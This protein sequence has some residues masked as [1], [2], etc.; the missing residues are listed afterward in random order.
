MHKVGGVLARGQL[1]YRVK[2]FAEAQAFAIKRHAS[3]A[4]VIGSGER[5]TVEADMR[6]L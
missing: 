1:A 6:A 2:E 4:R 5:V 3:A